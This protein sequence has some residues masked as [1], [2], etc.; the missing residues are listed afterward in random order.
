ME[1]G[2]KENVEHAR[3]ELGV[4]QDGDSSLE[5]GSKTVDSRFIVDVDRIQ[6]QQQQQSQPSTHSRLQSNGSMLDLKRIFRKSSH[7]ST[8]SVSNYTLDSPV[9]STSESNLSSPEEKPIQSS[10]SSSK[11]RNFVHRSTRST[12]SLKTLYNHNDPFHKTSLS[13]HYG[14]LGKALGE[15]AGGSVRLVKRSS[16]KRIFAVK[17]FRQRQNYETGREYSKKVTAEYCIGLTLKHP[18]IIETVDIIYE[19]DR[20]YQIMEYCEYDLF[21]IV[22]SGKMSHREIYCDFKQ[23]MSAILYMHE[24][25]LAHR[26]LKLDNCVINSHGIVKL[27]DFGSAVVYKYPQSDKILPAHG[28]VG[29][30][31]YLA[32]EVVANLKYQSTPTDIWSAAIIFCCMLMRKFP[33][34]SPRLSDHSYK[35]FAQGQNNYNEDE[36]SETEKPP[37]PNSM[38]TETAGPRHSKSNGPQ[39]LLRNLPQ[40]VRPLVLKMLTIDPEKRATIQEC[41]EDDWFKAVEFCTMQ[42]GH[43]VSRPAHSHST[44]SFDEAHIAMLEK[45]NK[46]KKPKDKLW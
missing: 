22:M 11:L 6:Q 9:M 33:W 12:T 31:P 41:F 30:D 27:I 32:P 44:V 16:D 26:D 23:I 42:D 7:S 18:H 36:P 14:R 21:A 1:E 13:K 38:I 20:I 45:K 43:V 24:S 2:N 29:S 5:S 40:D 35:L 25:G 3:F 17:E 10:P 37:N 19:H 34:K 28:I 4:P 15:G 8:H 46:K 39:R